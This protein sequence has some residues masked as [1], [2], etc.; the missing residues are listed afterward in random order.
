MSTCPYPPILTAPTT[1]GAVPCFRFREWEEG[2][3]VRP[4]GGRRRQWWDDRCTRILLQNQQRP[5]AE[6]ADLI[7]AETGLRFSV[8]AVSSYRSALGC[9]GYKHDN[10]WTSPLRRWRPWQGH[11]RV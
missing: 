1:P 4:S 7:A 5:N 9:S 2:A 3:E 11:T 6:I 8:S 10:D